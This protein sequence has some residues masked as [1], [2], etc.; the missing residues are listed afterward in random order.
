MFKFRPL[1]KEVF[2]IK[3]GADVHIFM[4]FVSGS[5]YDVDFTLQHLNVIYVDA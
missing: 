3:T 5:V 1:H 2:M 4:N